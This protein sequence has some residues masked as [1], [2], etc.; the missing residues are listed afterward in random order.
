MAL[1]VLLS[2]ACGAALAVPGRRRDAPQPAAAGPDAAALPTGRAVGRV[3]PGECRSLLRGHQVSFEEVE[4]ERAPGVA[5]PIRLTGPVGGVTVASPSP[6]SNN[7]V[8]DCRLVLALLSWSSELAEAGIVRIDHASSYRPGARV[9]RTG[10]PSGHAA[11]LAVDITRFH[12]ADGSV[13]AVL[14]QWSPAEL[15]TDPC[16]GH[17]DDAEG[18]ATLRSLLCGV[19]DADLFQVVLT[20]H[21]DRTHR[22]H[23]HLE[24]RPD[25]EWSYVR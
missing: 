10:E 1:A 15:G 9:H 25:V 17:P 2:T 6:D 4:L 12:R 11:G 19:V 20:P 18:L 21:F 24:I 3:S 5:A 8:F 22:N 13:L 14:E 16:A 23:V 7:Q